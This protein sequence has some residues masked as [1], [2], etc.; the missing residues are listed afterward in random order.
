MII[1]PEENL[2]EILVGESKLSFWPDS[3]LLHLLDHGGIPLLVGSLVP[4]LYRELDNDL[5]PEIL[6][7]G[8]GKYFNLTRKWKD[9]RSD[10]RLVD[11]RVERPGADRVLVRTSYQLPQ[12]V[13]PFQISYLVGLDGELEVRCQFK[14]RYELLRLGLQMPISGALVYTTWF[15]RG[16]HETMPDRK[17]GGMEAIYH[18]PSSQIR[19]DYIHPQENGNR[20]DVRWV[21]FTNPQGQGIAVEQMDGQL[22]N[23]SLWPYTE[24][25]LLDAEHIHELP[26]RD[27]FTLNLDLAQRGVGD[28][29]SLMYGRDPDTRLRR[30]T[31]YRFGVRIKPLGD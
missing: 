20:T 31:T 9:F 27:C 3:G 8:V 24:G 13:G 1:H 29:F 18:L 12:G 14:P 16:P 4:N 15:G 23:F 22:L 21:K 19:H 25:D 6:L 11:F 30:G 5:L 10:L 26:E 2:L 28:L 17:T 7:P